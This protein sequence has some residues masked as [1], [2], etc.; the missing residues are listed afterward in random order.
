LSQPQLKTFSRRWL[1]IVL[2]LAGLFVGFLVLYRYVS[3]FRVDNVA[4]THDTYLYIPTGSDFDEVV[5]DMEGKGL[6]KNVGS[7]IKVSRKMGYDLHVKPGRYRVTPD[8]S[9][10]KLV[11][12]LLMGAQDPVRVT[13]HNIRTKQQLSGRISKQLEADSLSILTMLR[14]QVDAMAFGF[15]TATIMAMFIPN[16]YEFYWNTDANDFFTRMKKEYESFWTPEREQKAYRLGITRIDVS[17]LASIVEEETRMVTEM[18]I[19]AGV[20]LNRLHRGIPLQADPTVRFALGDF[21]IRRILSKHLQLDSPYN[22]Y[23]YKGLPPGPIR[24]PSIRAIDA[25]LNAEKHSYLYFCAKPDFSGY[26][27]FARTL[28]EHNRNAEAYRRALN[29]EKIFR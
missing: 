17:I 5:R 15:D 3:T 10:Q 16:T 11:N 14:S 29:R 1:P 7:F 26:H 19:I 18:P 13:F 8:M 12:K 24:C 21:S 2:A 23:K 25:V 6:L 9:N 28:M 20:Y 22:T 27:V 4:L